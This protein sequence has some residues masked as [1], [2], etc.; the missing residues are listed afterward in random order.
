MSRPVAL[1]LALAATGTAAA[2]VPTSTRHFSSPPS[3]LFREVAEETGLRFTHEPGAAGQYRLPEILG[4]GVALLD[5]DGDGDLD[6]FL[7][8]DRTFG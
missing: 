2:W 5:Y 4:S 8:Q 7:I 1:A 6:V 3:V